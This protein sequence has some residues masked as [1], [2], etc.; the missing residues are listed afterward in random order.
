MSEESS[1]KTYQMIKA[2]GFIGTFMVS[3]PV[4]AQVWF[5]AI[6]HGDTG[7]SFTLAVP[8]YIMLGG[9]HIL[10]FLRAPIPCRLAQLSHRYVIW[11]NVCLVG[12]HG[13]AVLQ[14]LFYGLEW[15]PWVGLT[16]A[17]VF[18]WL[19]FKIWREDIIPRLSD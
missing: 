2:D 13:M 15:L 17:V 11:R 14:L 16:G 1:Q 18:C 7:I 19:A 3:P 4:L 6:H 5:F 12:F 10:Y 8:V 9:L